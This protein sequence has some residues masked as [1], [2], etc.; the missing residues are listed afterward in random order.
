MAARVEEGR[1]S[2]DTLPVMSTRPVCQGRV[3][4]ASLLHAAEPGTAFEIAVGQLQR[5]VCTHLH[6]PVW[7]PGCALFRVRP[8][9]LDALHTS[10]ELEH[11][12]EACYRPHVLGAIF[13][14]GFRG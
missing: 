4:P 6:L 14:R 9:T 13:D 3:E 8:K 1:S 10:L 7:G 12:R 2:G 11:I 5:R